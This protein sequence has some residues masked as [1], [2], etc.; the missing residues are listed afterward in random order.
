MT[1]EPKPRSRCSAGG[2]WREPKNCRK[3]GSLKNGSRGIFTTLDEAM[4]TTAGK[5][6][7]R[8]GAKPIGFMDRA[9]APPAM[10]AVKIGTLRSPNTVWPAHDDSTKPNIPPV[11]KT[12]KS[13]RNAA[14][15]RMCTVCCIY[16]PL[17]FLEAARQ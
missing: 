5:A 17:W 10:R 6:G 13:T 7:F 15:W 9:S 12:K 1:P 3:K 2:R 11:T 4:L 8:I 14:D 16:N